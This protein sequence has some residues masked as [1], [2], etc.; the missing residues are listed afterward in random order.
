MGNE[1]LRSNLWIEMLVAIKFV[2]Q[3]RL[4]NIAIKSNFSLS[5]RG[6]HENF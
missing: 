6:E 3:S 4:G 1:K 2:L 5:I